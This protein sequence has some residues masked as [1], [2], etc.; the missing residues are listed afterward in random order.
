[1][2]LLPENPMMPRLRDD[3]V[4]YSSFSQVNFG[5]DEL[6]AA[7]QTFIRRWRLEPSDPEAYARG[8]LVDPV[9]PIV[10]YIDP[11][12]PARW[13][14]H[15]RQGIEAW[16]AAFETAGFSNAIASART[17]STASLR[18]T[19]DTSPSRGKPSA[20][21]RGFS[22]A[23]I[24]CVPVFLSSF[25]VSPFSIQTALPTPILESA[26][27]STVAPHPTPD[28]GVGPR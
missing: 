8:E 21:L 7:E 4:G 5:L 26:V 22:I 25:M 14:P 10:Y 16:Q 9:K 28:P 17:R 3:R 18:S 20:S 24:R 11:A 15:V 23:A 12:T 13:R 1:M 27:F 6:K 19:E 2:V